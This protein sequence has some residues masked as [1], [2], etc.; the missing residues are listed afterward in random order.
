MQLDV[1]DVCK[2]IEKRF[3]VLSLVGLILFA[4]G[5]TLAMG[6]Q[7]LKD[8]HSDYYYYEYDSTDESVMVRTAGAMISGLGI[9]TTIA[10]LLSAGF[11]SRNIDSRTRVMLIGAGTGLLFV[12]MIITLIFSLM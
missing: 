8:R 4:G 11:L 10:G 5:M 6:S 12:M 1:K 7:L 3:L 2:S 9:L